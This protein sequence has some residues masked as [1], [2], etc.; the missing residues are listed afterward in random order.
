MMFTSYEEVYVGMVRS[1][2][3]SFSD[4]RGF[5]YRRNVVLCQIV[6]QNQS[7]NL[8]LYRSIQ[9]HVHSY[10]HYAIQTVSN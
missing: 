4:R 9:S 2:E 7:N 3:I 1:K 8:S 5:Y 10:F 6:L